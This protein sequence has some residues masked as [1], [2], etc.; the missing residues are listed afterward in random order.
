MSNTAEIE[1]TLGPTSLKSCVAPW[2]SLG[3]PLQDP[4]KQQKSLGF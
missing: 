1:R 3:G 2:A 4:L